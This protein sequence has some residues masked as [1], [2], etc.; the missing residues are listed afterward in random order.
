F[1]IL[2]SLRHMARIPAY[3]PEARG[4]IYDGSGLLKNLSFYF[5]KTN[6]LTFLAVFSLAIWFIWNM[7]SGFSFSQSSTACL[8]PLILLLIPHTLIGL[9]V[10]FNPKRLEG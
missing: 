2:H 8:V 7:Y 3:I 9:L 5:Q 1:L 10:D 6:F 4:Q